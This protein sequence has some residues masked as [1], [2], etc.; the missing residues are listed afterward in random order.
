MIVDEPAKR[1]PKSLSAGNVGWHPDHMT[2]KT[3]TVPV[4][5]SEVSI[6]A[7]D[8]A[9]WLAERLSIGLDVVAVTTPRYTSVTA[10][11]LTSL[12]DDR[13]K[14]SGATQRVLTAD[15]D[16]IE[17]RLVAEVLSDPDALW[18]VGSHGRTALG[19]LLFGSVS[20]DLVRDARV[21]IIVV[22][23]HATTRKD[24]K[25]LAV[26]VD[27]TPLGESIL[28][29]A[30]ELAGRLGLRLRLLQ[31][32]T[33]HGPSDTIDTAYL[34]RLSDHLPDPDN[35]DYETLYGDADEELVSYVE[36]R[37]DVGMLCMAT[38]GVPAGA[39]LSV[40]STALRVLHHVTV[41]VLLLHPVD[42][43]IEPTPEEAFRSG[44]LVDARRRVVVGVDSYVASA[45]AVEWAIQEAERLD[46]VLQIVHTWSLPVAPGAEYGY[47]M[48]ADI[49]ALRSEALDEVART[50]SAV[51]ASHPSLIVETIV[52]E[53]DPA[54]VIAQQSDGALAVVLGRHHHGRLASLFVGHTDA[55]ALHRVTCPI[56]IVPCGDRT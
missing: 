19:E 41:P 18:C 8:H 40:A 21:P 14:G 27:G 50:G 54:R 22:G 42:V 38:R 2:T 11:A 13:L 26:A 5:F 3:V 37:D 47:P 24:A 52:A 6:A 16:D 28:P 29:A 35:A 20:A 33:A 43:E 56:V 44:T 51:A 36:R 17:G 10:A 9:R 49:D 15:D 12:V 1:G 39:R 48:M 53:G 4:D 46:A 34:S 7:L 30:V 31:V 55:S 25:V 32:G 45:P 23:R